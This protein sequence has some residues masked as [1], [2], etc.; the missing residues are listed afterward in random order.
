MCTYQNLSFYAN[1]QTKKSPRHP[2]ALHFSMPWL[3]SWLLLGA[4][5]LPGDRA[6]ALDLGCPQVSQP[7]RT[8]AQPTRRSLI[9]PP[10][11]PCKGLRRKGARAHPLC[12]GSSLALEETTRCAWRQELLQVQAALALCLPHIPWRDAASLPSRLCASTMDPLACPSRPVT[13][14]RWAPQPQR[15]PEAPP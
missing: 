11:G 13:K 14:R 9:R 4:F 8:S 1:E 7:M 15:Q 2:G 5:C 6:M 12:P 3:A 10:F